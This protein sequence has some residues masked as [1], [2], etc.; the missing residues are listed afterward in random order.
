MVK[1]WVDPISLE[2]HPEHPP[3]GA[4]DPEGVF[5][6]ASVGGFLVDVGSH[7]RSYSRKAPVAEG[8]ARW[9]QW[10]HNA[11]RGEAL[12]TAKA[13]LSNIEVTRAVD[14]CGCIA[15]HK[16]GLLSRAGRHL[17]ITDGP[18]LYPP[19]PGPSPVVLD[20]IR[21]AFPGDDERAVFLGWLAG[22]L[23]AVVAGVHSPAPMMVLAGPPNTGKSLL[24]WI[25]T[26]LLGG[27]VGHPFTAWT[28]RL[29]WNDDLIGAE[30]LLIDDSVATIN[31][32]SRREFAARFKEAIF[33]AE[34]QMLKRHASAISVRPVW[35][36]MVCC[37]DNPESLAI[38]PPIDDDLA[39][40]V[41]ILRV[42]RVTPPVDT[43]T[44][45]GKRQ[46]QEMV[47]AELPRFARLLSQF[48]IP[49][50]LTD[51][52]TGVRA[53]RDAELSATLDAIT[54]ERRL[55][56]M[57]ALAVERGE[58]NLAPGEAVEL[59][60][61]DIEA[62][63]CAG[64]SPVRDGARSLLAKYDGACGRYLGKLA[65]ADRP[66]RSEY[67][68]RGAVVRGVQRWKIQRPFE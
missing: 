7:Y 10:R 4:F 67:V 36:V 38:I 9:L 14:W 50:H 46:L 22:G 45:E 12:P 24:A 42:A 41:S 29:P 26:K 39:D 35:R 6:A 11:P 62:R 58:F 44:P 28:G 55:E 25:A 56:Q 34:V 2:D 37:N 64:D 17:L 52:R 59:P 47:V 30:L 63:L 1:A 43:S 51:P 20:I 53:W 57:L 16:R 15:G 61:A 5:Y 21:Q 66:A 40:K 54:P 13:E 68:A 32:H 60:A 65:P 27:R 19:A 31:I 18:E 3:E 23:A 8:I 49:E 33:G 48:T